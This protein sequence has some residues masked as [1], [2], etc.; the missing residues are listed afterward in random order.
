MTSCSKEEPL[1]DVGQ[2]TQQVISSLGSLN[3]SD[4]KMIYQKEVNDSTRASVETGFYKLDVNGNEVKLVIKNKQGEET[5]VEITAIRNINERYMAFYPDIWQIAVDNGLDGGDLG[6]Y[7]CFVDRHTNKISAIDR[8]KIITDKFSYNESEMELSNLIGIDLFNNAPIYNFSNAII[9]ILSGR[10]AKIDIANQT[11]S[12]VLP[13]GQ[14]YAGS[15]VHGFKFGGVNNNGDI[16]YETNKI[17]LSSSGIQTTKGQSFILSNQIYNING[18]SICVLESDNNSNLIPREVATIPT[19]EQFESIE[20]MTYNPVKKSILIFC[21]NF[22]SGIAYEFNGN[23][24]QETGIDYNTANKFYSALF[25]GIPA[26]RTSAAWY[27]RDGNSFTKIDFT[28]WEVSNFT[29]GGI[30]IYNISANENAPEFGFTGLNYSDASQVFGTVKSDNTI[31][32][33]GIVPSSTKIVNMIPL[34]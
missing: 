32:I 19:S 4:A 14:S 9:Y 20:L 29:L 30:E 22:Y 1:P 33:N 28:N 23:S 18:N 2:L 24:L 11:V 12:L 3:I 34:D 26:F 17:F 8:N 6:D 10:M 16:L 13:E 7:V 5:N 15:S 21:R 31:D 27:L 25:M